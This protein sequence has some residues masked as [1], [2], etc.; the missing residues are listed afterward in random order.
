M[1]E[2]LGVLLALAVI[3]GLWA[4]VMSSNVLKHQEPATSPITDLD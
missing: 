2:V 3:I 1:K 4:L